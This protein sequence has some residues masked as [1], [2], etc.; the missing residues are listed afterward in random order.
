VLYIED[1]AVNSLLVEQLLA[2]WPDVRFIRAMDGAS[3]MQMART[4]QP[5]LVLMDLQLPDLDGVELLERLRA[6]SALRDTPM[7]VLSASAMP[8]DIARARARGA[9]DY[10]TKPLDFQQFLAGVA[11]A[12]D[13]AAVD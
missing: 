11:R 3:G 10:W 2:R 4:L 5:D 8:E 12:L 13:S 1:N 7:I 9:T 6:D